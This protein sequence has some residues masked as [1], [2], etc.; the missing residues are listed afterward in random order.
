MHFRIISGDFTQ[1]CHLK[2][3]FSHLCFWVTCKICRYVTCSNSSLSEVILINWSWSLHLYILHALY[4]FYTDFIGLAG[5]ANWGLDSVMLWE[6]WQ[7][8]EHLKLLLISVPRKWLGNAV[9]QCSW[10][11]LTRSASKLHFSWG[12]DAITF[13]MCKKVCSIYSKHWCCRLKSEEQRFFLGMTG[14]FLDIQGSSA[15]QPCGL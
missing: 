7:S 9:L 14:P 6:T 5:G 2:W 12:A 15:L 1:L 4:R 11:T 3:P 10:S 13:G 8:L